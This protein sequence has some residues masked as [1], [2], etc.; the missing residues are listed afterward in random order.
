PLFHS[1]HHTRDGSLC[2]GNYSNTLVIWDRLFGSE[3]TR[4]QPPETY[5]LE[6][7]QALKFGLLS[8]Q[9]LRRRD[10]AQAS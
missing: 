2:D 10:A 9:M 4:P 6:G 8:M 3:V 7:D 1:W 5:G